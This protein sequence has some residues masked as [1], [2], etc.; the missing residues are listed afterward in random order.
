MKKVIGLVA[1][2]GLTF[3]L[4][5]CAGQSPEETCKQYLHEFGTYMAAVME[6]DASAESNFASKLTQLST[7]A[8]AEIRTALLADAV[9]VANSTETA[10]ACSSYIK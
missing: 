5:G 8:P 10:K 3:S 4:S 7:N 1:V 9:D 6:G 2:V